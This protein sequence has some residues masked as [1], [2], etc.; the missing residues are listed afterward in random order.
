MT[1]Q[2]VANR[3]V[4]LCRQ[5][6][7]EETQQELFA[8][9]CISIEPYGP[10]REVKGKQEIIDKGKNFMSMVEEFH[11]SEISDPIVSG[12][13]FSIGWTMEATMKGKSREKMQE[14]CVYKVNDGKIVSE[15]FFS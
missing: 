2:Q 6:K 14:I 8:D 3:L 15:Q 12:N 1:T 10:V 4:E 11:G 7:I 5:G 9:D 13:H